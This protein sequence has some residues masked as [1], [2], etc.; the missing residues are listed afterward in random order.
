MVILFQ[1]ESANDKPD[2]Q[3][4][5][6][7]DTSNDIEITIE[8]YLA[9]NEAAAQLQDGSHGDVR[10]GLDEIEV[11][12]SCVTGTV[13]YSNS[14]TVVTS[15]LSYETVTS[16]SDGKEAVARV[17][18]SKWSGRDKQEVF[19]NDNEATRE[20]FELE[21]RNGLYH[22]HTESIGVKYDVSEGILSKSEDSDIVQ[23]KDVE[24]T[25]IDRFITESVGPNDVKLELPVADSYEVNGVMVTKI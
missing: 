21:E 25:N 3:T 14:I 8:D 18:H 19:S 6:A 9:K 10:N 16:R 11:P 4:G 23:P 15:T 13:T 2:D 22:A 12:A 5:V 1:A 20:D 7:M 17:P 24:V